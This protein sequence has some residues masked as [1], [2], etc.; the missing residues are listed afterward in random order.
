MNNM[1]FDGNGFVNN[2]GNSKYW[3]VAK[4]QRDSSN[5]RVQINIEDHNYT[6][7]F[8]TRVKEEFA[9]KAATCL[10]SAVDGHLMPPIAF[11][12]EGCVYRAYG[13]VIERTDWIDNP[14]VVFEEIAD[15]IISPKSILSPDEVDLVKLVYDDIVKNKLTKD[16][17]R[18][19]RDMMNQLL[20]VEN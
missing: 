19:I 9:A 8:K 3:G 14:N 17:A 6:F 4:C 16:G 5:W 12:I 2:R 18:L 10:K 11:K 20:K 13:G 15:R 1:V 7:N